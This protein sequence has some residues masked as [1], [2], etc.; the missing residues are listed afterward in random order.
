MRELRKDMQMIFQ[1][2]FES[3]NSR[4]TIGHILEEPLL[5][6]GLELLKNVKKKLKDFLQR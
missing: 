1:D 2:P 6:M 3:L 4:H 5:F